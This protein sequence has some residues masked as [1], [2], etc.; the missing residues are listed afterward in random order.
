MSVLHVWLRD[1]VTRE[2]AMR[3]ESRMY[4]LSLSIWTLLLVLE[5]VGVGESVQVSRFGMSDGDS[6]DQ[7]V[8]VARKD[9]QQ[10]KCQLQR[11]M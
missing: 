5:I 9:V 2:W 1:Q 7:S 11:G 4:F 6:T 10:T 3:N 8:A